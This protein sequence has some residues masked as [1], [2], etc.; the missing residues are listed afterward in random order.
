MR[1]AALALAAM[2]AAPAASAASIDVKNPWIRATPPGALTAAGYATITNRQ[3]T[4]DRL[5]GGHT[6]AAASVEVHSMSMSGGVMRM[7]PIPGGL[8][9]AASATVT[10]G[11]NGD[12]LMLIGLKGPLKAG[13]HVRLTLQFRRAGAVTV[14]FPVLAGPPGAPMGNMRM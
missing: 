11:P 1:L 12:H 5:T 10:L 3:I 13:Q 7:R 9:I 2:V 14:D 8:A 4:S 6:S